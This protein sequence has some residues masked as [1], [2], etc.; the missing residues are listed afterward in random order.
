MRFI[1]FK[2]ERRLDH[3]IAVDFTV[4]RNRTSS[5][6]ASVLLDRTLMTLLKLWQIT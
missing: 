3:G 6:T 2:L 1:E 5:L 4:Q